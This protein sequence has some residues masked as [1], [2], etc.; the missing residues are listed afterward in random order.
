METPDVVWH[1]TGREINWL[2]MKMAFSRNLSDL[3]GVSEI[4]SEWCK[5]HLS[6]LHSNEKR[7]TLLKRVS[8]AY[9]TV[10]IFK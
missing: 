8:Y 1:V 4:P 3:Q 5:A 10:C 6:E 9:Y 2:T 7:H